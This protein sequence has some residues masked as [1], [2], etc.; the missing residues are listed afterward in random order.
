MSAIGAVMVMAGVSLSR[1]GFR[2]LN[3]LGPS[4]RLV[5]WGLPAALGDAGQLAAVCHLAKA[6]AAEP[7]FA[8]HGA[9]APAALASGIAAHGEF[10][11][12]RRLHPQR[13]LRH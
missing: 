6:D 2:N 13:C 5:C 12:A 7:E 3:G 11:L 9:R 10:R 8:I 4:A 1:C